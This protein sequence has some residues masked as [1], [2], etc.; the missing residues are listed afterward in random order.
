[1]RLFVAQVIVSTTHGDTQHTVN[2]QTN[3]ILNLTPSG[4]RNYQLILSADRR[5]F[6]EE[7]N[8]VFILLFINH[9]FNWTIYCTQKVSTKSTHKKCPKKVLTKS[10]WIKCPQK[11]SKSSHKIV[12]KNCPKNVS[13]KSVHKSAGVGGEGKGGGEGLTNE[14]AGNWSCDSR[15]DERLHKKLYPMYIKSPKNSFLNHWRWK[16][17]FK[18]LQNLSC[19]RQVCP[20]T[21]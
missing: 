1:M 11:V 8:S 17:V 13:T 3:I 20:I 7:K 18:Y 12:P 15:A 14:R 19:L 4:D 5:C 2:K 21:G 9:Y 16:K 6:L 10:V